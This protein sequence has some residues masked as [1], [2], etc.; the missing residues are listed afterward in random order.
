MPL[1]MT[2]NVGTRITIGTAVVEVLEIG[3]GRQAMLDI[4]GV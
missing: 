1:S 4:S 3:P 2:I